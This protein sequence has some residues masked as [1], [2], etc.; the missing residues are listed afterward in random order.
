MRYRPCMGNWPWISSKCPTQKQTSTRGPR[1]PAMS[2]RFRRGTRVRLVTHQF[3]T[4]LSCYRSSTIHGMAHQRSQEAI[5]ALHDRI[6]KV[7]HRVMES[8]GRSAVDSIGI[9]LHLMGLL[10]TI[11]L[12]WLS[13]QSHPSRPGIPP[14]HSLMHPK[15][16]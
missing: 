16:A 7:I 3:F 8:A 6:W 14:G 5:Q 1:Q 4:L 10:L 2:L 13:I 9:A 15:I 12:H 11:P